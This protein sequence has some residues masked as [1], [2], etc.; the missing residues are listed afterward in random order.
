[1]GNSMVRI[2]ALAVRRGIAGIDLQT[3]TRVPIMGFIGAGA[4]IDPEYESVP[5]MG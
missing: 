2:R 4:E 3:R 5:L 1:M